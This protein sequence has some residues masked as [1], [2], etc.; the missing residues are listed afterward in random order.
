MSSASGRSYDEKILGNPATI[1][2]HVIFP[3]RMKPVAAFSIDG[4]VAKCEIFGS[5]VYFYESG[6]FL[7]HASDGT[8]V[9]ILVYR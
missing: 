5:S 1:G 9:K 4:K 3:A 2:M 7:V 8:V 6:M